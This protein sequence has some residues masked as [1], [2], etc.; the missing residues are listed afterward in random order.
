[1]ILDASAV[2]AIVLDEPERRALLEKL[3]AADVL[4]IGAPTATEAAIALSATRK[5]DGYD[6]VD[7][8]IRAADIEVVS[9]TAAHWAEAVD[10]FRRFGKG[11]HP[12]RL[13]FGD[14]LSYAV[15]RLANRPLL[16][17]G[18]DFSKTDLELA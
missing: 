12:A 18:S 5:I 2:I 3:S 7:R 4:G 14:C 10:A 16:C 8:F 6:L 17:V 13:N 9:F 11:R 1:M 15:A